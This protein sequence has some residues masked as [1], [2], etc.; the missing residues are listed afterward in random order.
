MTDTPYAHVG[1]FVTKDSGD[2]VEFDSGMKRDTQV[3][4]PRYDLCD[5]GMYK[6]WA[7]LMGR[8]AD[9]YGENNWRKANSKSELERFKASAERHLI[10]WLNGEE[11]EDHGAAVI[12]NIA[13]HEATKLKLKNQ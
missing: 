3:G 11:D 1:G 9:K 12:F 10:S 2:R 13:A 6:R 7:E 8:G 4:K 5:K